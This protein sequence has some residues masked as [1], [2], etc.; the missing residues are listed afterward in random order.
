MEFY[1]AGFRKGTG[2]AHEWATFKTRNPKAKLICID[3][4]PNLTAQIKPA[5]DVLCVG[6]FSDN[7]FS[8]MEAFADNEKNDPDFWV[9]K[10]EQS[11]QIGF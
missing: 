10:I 4:Q 6:G 7:V 3:M 11:S 8:I 2:L 5:Q 1:N 9:S